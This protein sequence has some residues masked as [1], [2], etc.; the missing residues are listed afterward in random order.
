[1][2]DK[3]LNIEFIYYNVLVL[4]ETGGKFFFKKKQ[5]KIY[6]IFDQCKTSLLFFY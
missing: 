3:C 5:H 4:H 1:M 6:L 2:N